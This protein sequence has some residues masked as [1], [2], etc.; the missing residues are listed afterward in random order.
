MQFGIDIFAFRT[1]A[2]QD[3]ASFEY[4]NEICPASS[5]WVIINPSIIG[6]RRCVDGN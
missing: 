2:K 5:T 6:I 4:W 3:G 1:F